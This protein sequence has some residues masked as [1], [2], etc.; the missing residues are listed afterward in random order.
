[1]NS[2]SKLGI[3]DYELYMKTFQKAIETKYKSIKPTSPYSDLANSLFMDNIG[4]KKINNF[5]CI[6]G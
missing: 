4:I 1:M 3:I 2:Y 5:G 6:I